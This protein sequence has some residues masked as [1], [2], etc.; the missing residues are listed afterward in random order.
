MARAGPPGRLKISDVVTFADGDVLDVPGRPRVIHAPGHSDGS[1]ALHF[2]GHSALLVGDVLCSFNPLTGRRG[3]QV[4]PG[5]FA[6]SSAQA[7]ESVGRLE[8]VEAAVVGFGH[9]DPWRGGVGAAVA[10]ARATGTT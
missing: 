5:A 10:E 1:V 4:M 8:G 7:L 2:A 6:V 9:G 3:V